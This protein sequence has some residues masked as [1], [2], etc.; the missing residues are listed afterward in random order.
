MGAQR[1]AFFTTRLPAILYFCLHELL[2][3]VNLRYILSAAFLWLSFP[4]VSQTAGGSQSNN[5]TQPTTRRVDPTCDSA[6]QFADSV[7]AR[8]VFLFETLQPG[9]PPD[10]QPILA[11][12]NNAIATDKE[13]FKEYRNKYTATG[14]PLPYDEH[15]GITS[16]E[17]QKLQH[18]ESQPLQL[19]VVD[20][21]KVTVSDDH[22]LI[23]FTSGGSNHLLD[24]LIIDIQHQQ[25]MYGGDTIPFKG[26]A[27]ANTK[28]S[29]PIGEAKGYTWRLEK[30]DVAATLKA[31]KPT[32][33]VVEIDLG[34]TPQPG[35]TYIRIEY[36]DVDAGVTTANLELIGY[37]R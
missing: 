21:Q 5:T 31:G 26:P 6:F 8:P 32:A 9:I 33:R 36:Q 35:K 1:Y 16:E 17:Y 37:I 11:R 27:D 18:L 24:Y 22:G 29:N 4:G 23:R 34:R 7:F 15:F 10:M 30:T 28:P 19:V 14:Q 3:M 2:P 13:W 25:L 20:S 12:M